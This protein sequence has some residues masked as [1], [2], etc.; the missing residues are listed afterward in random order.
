MQTIQSKSTPNAIRAVPRGLKA[1]VTAIST[2]AVSCLMLPALSTPSI[3]S[4][5]DLRLSRPSDTSQL[6]PVRQARVAPQVS[7][8]AIR[9]PKCYWVDIYTFKCT[10]VG[11]M[12]EVARD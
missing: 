10:V 12:N 7:D 11:P 8:E 6:L 2:L 4:G 3:A 9:I 1:G 5:P